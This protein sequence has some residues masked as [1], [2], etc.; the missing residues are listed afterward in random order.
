MNDFNCS[1]ARV[2]SLAILFCICNEQMQSEF[3]AYLGFFLGLKST[4]GI[5]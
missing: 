4:L 1:G 3:T 2:V 5:L